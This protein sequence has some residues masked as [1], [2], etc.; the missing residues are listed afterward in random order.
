MLRLVEE[1]NGVQCLFDT[2][3]EEILVS[4]E[5][6]KKE[7]RRKKK[8]KATGVRLKDGRVLAA[9]LVISNVDAPFTNKY[10]LP[11]T[12]ARPHDHD[13]KQFSSSVVS[14]LWALDKPMLALRHHSTFLAASDEKEE[15]EEDDAA[16]AAWEGLFTHNRF[17]PTRFNF[18]V[19]AP[20]RTDPSVCPPGH[21]AIMVLVPCPVL[22]IDGEEEEEEEE[23]EMRL[24]AAAK[25]AVLQRF[26][27]MNGMEEFRRHIIHERVIAPREWRETYSLSRG[28]VFGL[29]HNLGQLSLLRP[30]PRSGEGIGG[31]YHCGA[32][33]RPGN[34]VP[35][36]MVGAK[37]LSEMIVKEHYS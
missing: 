18:Y 24:V 23:E 27:K 34:G 5:E 8:K 13:R 22:G 29:R 10:L 26:E 15:E 1:E 19:H 3:V 31:L 32:S 6:E 7:G 2:P 9:D 25:E 20:A 35:L 12:L 36:V 30:G 4:E 28:A 11:P 16:K 37:L 14:F 17:D 21:D 33:N